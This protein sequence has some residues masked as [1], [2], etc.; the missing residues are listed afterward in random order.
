MHGTSS[1][2]GH[3]GGSDERGD[4][5]SSAL[6]IG[7]AETRAAPTT[8]S[9]KLSPACAATRLLQTARKAILERHLIW[10]PRFCLSMAIA[11]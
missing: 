6:A 10:R 3:M 4:V 1:H 7:G 9:P 11:Q 8:T 5:E 2:G